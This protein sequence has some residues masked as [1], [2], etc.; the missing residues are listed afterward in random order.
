MN[1]ARFGDYN[2]DG[3]EDFIYAD[4][5]YGPVPPNSQGICLGGPSIDFV[6]DVVFEP[7]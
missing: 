5:Y 2:G 3:Y 6:P 7:R 4:A 1:V